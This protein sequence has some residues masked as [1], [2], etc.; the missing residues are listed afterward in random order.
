ML[1]IGFLANNLELSAK[2]LLVPKK[3][4]IIMLLSDFKCFFN[5][6][7][8]ILDFSPCKVIAL[9]LLCFILSKKDQQFEDL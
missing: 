5:I 6:A 1:I 2:I 3:Y 9:N 7:I 4:K 8:A